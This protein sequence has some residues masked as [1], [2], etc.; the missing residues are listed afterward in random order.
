MSTAVWAMEHAMG[1]QRTCIIPL[2]SSIM[3]Y[4]EMKYDSIRLGKIGADHPRG[5]VRQHK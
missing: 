4:L 5:I 3:K 1:M 2:L